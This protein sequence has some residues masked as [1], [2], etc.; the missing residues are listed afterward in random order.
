MKKTILQE[1]D[2]QFDFYAFFEEEF[3]DRRPLAVYSDQNLNNLRAAEKTSALDD[4]LAA[5]KLMFLYLPGVLTVHFL[6]LGFGFTFYYDAVLIDILPGFSGILA[7]ATFMMM[8]G[9]G[10]MRDLKYL[11]VVF[12]AL[13]TSMFFAV[14]FSVMFKFGGRQSFG[15][16]LLATWLPSAFVGFWIKNQLDH[17]NEC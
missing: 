12:S 13:L 7:V 9:I 11:R 10:K 3:S 17:Q 4:F 5:L 2:S 14:V 6:A 15:W 16:F 8:F 1:K